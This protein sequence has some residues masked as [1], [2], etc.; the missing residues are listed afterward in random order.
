MVASTV[1]KSRLLHRLFMK[2]IWSNPINIYNQ[3]SDISLISP[4]SHLFNYCI[5][6]SFIINWTWPKKKKNHWMI[7]SKRSLRICNLFSIRPHRTKNFNFEIKFPTK[8]ILRIGLKFSKLFIIRC[9][10]QLNM[11]KFSFIQY[12]NLYILA[13]GFETQILKIVHCRN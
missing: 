3:L 6:F 9:W 12:L 5:N 11:F 10:L 1:K 2:L 7:Y 8:I 4:T 13:L